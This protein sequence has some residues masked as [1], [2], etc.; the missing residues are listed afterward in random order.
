MM[1][2]IV[3]RKGIYDQGIFYASHDKEEAIVASG[4]IKYKEKSE[5]DDYH[6]YEVRELQLD[7]IK[8]PRN[9]R[10]GHFSNFAQPANTIAINGVKS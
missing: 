7:F 9:E 10:D 1:V 4:V 6:D 5:L 3:V 2:Y 8:E